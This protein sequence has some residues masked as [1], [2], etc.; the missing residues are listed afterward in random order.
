MSRGCSSGSLEDSLKTRALRYIENMRR[1]LSE[2]EVTQTAIAI[3]PLEVE[4]LLDWVR[5]YVEDSYHFLDKGDLASS[6]VAICYAEGIMEAL[7]LLGLARFE[8]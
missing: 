4:K 1:I 3:D 5:N 7:R 2:I 8:W 6:L